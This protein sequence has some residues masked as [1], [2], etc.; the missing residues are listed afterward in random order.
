MWLS[1]EI[2]FS[3]IASFLWLLRN[4]L[5]LSYDRNAG[6]AI[7]MGRAG[8]SPDMRFAV[9]DS[10]DQDHRVTDSYTGSGAGR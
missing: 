10:G 4:N 1:P 5:Q 6:R 9:C 2:S 3:G 7:E 8:R